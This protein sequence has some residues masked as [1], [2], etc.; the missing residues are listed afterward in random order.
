MTSDGPK[1]I[2]LVNWM[3]PTHPRA[4]GAERHLREIFGRLARH[5]RITLVAAGYPGARRVA[6]VAGMR[7][8]R[9]GGTFD[10]AV[11]APIVV[12]RLLRRHRFD[13]LIE[14]LNKIPLLLPRTTPRL[15]LAHH[16]WGAVAFDAA[17]L[18]IALLTWLA[19]R[20]LGRI[21]AGARVA[22]VSPST[23][24]ELIERGIPPASI[25]VVENAVDPPPAHTA[26]RTTEPLFVYVG[27]LQRYKRVELLI[28]AA[29]TLQRE[30]HRFRVAII[31]QGPDRARL[32]GL[33][34]K[35]P[36]LPI[37][38]LGSVSDTERD[39]ILA[40]A[41]ANVL[42]SRKEGFGLTVLEA[43]RM[44]TPSVVA[45]APGLQDAVRHLD[46]GLWVPYH[47]I[48]T[49]ADALR[50][51]IHNP[52]A[53]SRLGASAQRRVAS[54]GWDRAAIE[55]DATVRDAISGAPPA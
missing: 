49:L 48:L 54:R 21:Y 38:F 19:E 51:L 53:V 28:D 25:V 50:Y 18:P 3:D 10:F 35:D 15:M 45:F 43:S 14:D 11:R 46:D 9:V 44:G 7:V 52:D 40:S 23:R 4:G 8:V 5:H 31:G 33:V 26:P 55:M 47:H 32:E 2:L 36:E 22:A 34:R 12:R 24:H 37:R 41:W 1:R 13:L 16:L 29:R 20:P 6:R 17:P 30:G 39:D 42:M 27:R